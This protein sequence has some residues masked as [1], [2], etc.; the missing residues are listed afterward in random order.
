MEVPPNAIVDDVA[1]GES[2]R[3][4]EGRVWFCDWIDGD[5]ISVA[6]G[7]NDREVHAHVDGFPICIDWDLDNRL[8]IVDG[9]GRRLLRVSEGESQELAD[10]SLVSDK[11]WNEIAAH[12]S[13]RVFVNGIGFDMMAGDPPATGHVAVVDTD[14]STRRVVDGL[15]F[16]N[17]MTVTHDGST[18][19]VAESHAGRI[20]AFA[21]HEDG[22]LG[23]ARVFAEIPG[24]APD[25][26]CLADDGSVWYADVPNRRCQQVAEGG[27][28]RETITVDRGCFS[29][30]VSPSGSLYV[31]ATVWDADTFSTRRGVVYEFPPKTSS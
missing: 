15:A 30:A 31:A 2:L 9:A 8:L 16:P 6:P 17:G 10:L 3:W 23:A 26:L 24:S 21:I 4:H 19:L 27:E 13:G 22:D 7:G 28:V 5:V 18:L 29:C 12:P 11:P 14:G 1:F 25:G 20:T